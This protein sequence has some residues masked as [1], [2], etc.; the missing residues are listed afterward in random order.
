M[1]VFFLSGALYDAFEQTHATIAEVHSTQD[2]AESSMTRLLNE[3]IDYL[4]ECRSADCLLW[5]SVD[6]NKTYH[7]DCVCV[8]AT[9]HAEFD[10]SN[11]KHAEQLFSFA[12]YSG[13]KAL[14]VSFAPEKRYVQIGHLKICKKEI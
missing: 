9:I 11:E 7:N 6:N 12:V 13:I 3:Q 14:E 10:L 2:E 4:H 8:S 5:F 1:Q